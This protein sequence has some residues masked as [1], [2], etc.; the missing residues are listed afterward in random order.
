MLFD[1]LPLLFEEVLD[2][3]LVVELIQLHGVDPR[4]ESAAE[5]SNTKH[6][7]ILGSFWR[8]AAAQGVVDDLLERHLQQL[9]PLLQGV[10]EVIVQ[11]ERGSHAGIKA[12]LTRG[13][14]VFDRSARTMTATEFR[15]K[16]LGLMDEVAE[17][18]REIVITKRRRPAARMVRVR[19]PCG[20]LQILPVGYDAAETERK[21]HTLLDPRGSRRNV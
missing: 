14:K 3:K 10:G 8:Q 17:T 5:R 9:R 20:R 2:L 21:P 15:A 18:G 1:E 7:P 13:V 19:R 12:S 11:G 16:C 4:P 6:W